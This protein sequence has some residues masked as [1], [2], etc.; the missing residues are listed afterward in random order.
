MTGIRRAS[1]HR[2]GGA[3][4][5]AVTAAL[6]LLI[7]A[8]ALYANRS[9]V[10]EARTATSQVHHMQAFEAAQAGVEHML[11]KLVHNNV[12]PI[13]ST[14]LSVNN[15]QSYL[16]SVTSRPSK[17]L[18]IDSLGCADGCDPCSGS[19]PVKARIT[20]LAAWVSVLPN[21][22]TATLTARASA[23]IAGNAELFNTDSRH[24]GTT[25]RA[26]GTITTDAGDP[27]TV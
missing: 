3:V 12:T 15:G 20:Q 1:R 23:R 22:P 7:S 16:V 8:A 18:L 13:A 17:A 26:G 5:L 6:L 24:G 4:T 27:G 9:F 11:A 14:T 21:V 19:C 2:Q 10:V 25:V